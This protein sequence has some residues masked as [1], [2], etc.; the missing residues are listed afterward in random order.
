VSA[1]NNV[2]SN[3]FKIKIAISRF[4]LKIDNVREIKI[5]STDIEQISM[6]TFSSEKYGALLS[7]V[8]NWK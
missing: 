3:K 7:L 2:V 5:K 4:L 1:T 8:E 6:M